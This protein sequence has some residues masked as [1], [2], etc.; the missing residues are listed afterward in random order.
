MSLTVIGDRNDNPPV[1]NLPHYTT[2]IEENCPVGRRV[3]QVYTLS[4][5]VMDVYVFI[6]KNFQYNSFITLSW[7]LYYL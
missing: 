4:I 6:L 5:V 1:F 7:A 2:S 3:K